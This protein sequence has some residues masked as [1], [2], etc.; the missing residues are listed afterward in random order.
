MAEGIELAKAYVQIIPSA[1]GIQGNL[2]AALT[3]QATAAGK[4]AGKSMFGAMLGVEAVKAAAGGLTSFAKS[5][6]EVG[7]EFDSSMSQ[8]AATLGYTTEE[9]SD[10]GSEASQTL[11]TLRAFAR[12]MGATTA[13]SAAEAAD[14]LNYMALAGYDAQT[15]MKMLPNVLNLAAAGGLDLATASDMITDAGSALNLT[16]ED[17]SVNVALV[18]D[19]V[20][21][22]AKASSKS[23][24]SVGQLG[25]AILTIGGTAN[26][27]AGGTERLSTVLGLLADNGIK[28]S[29][30]GTHLRNMILKLASPTDDGAAAMEALGLSVFDAEGKM[31]D[32]QDIFGDL[33]KAFEGMTDEKKVQYISA[34]FNSRDIAS[35]N[36][37]LNTT[38]ERWDELAAAIVDSKDA[39]GA[40]AD[41][42]LDNL[43][44]DTKILESAMSE[45]KITLSQ[46]MSP[47]IRDITQGATGLITDV[48][49]W[50]KTADIKG[51]LDAIVGVIN[52]V[53]G[54]ISPLTDEIIE[55]FSEQEIASG[56]AEAFHSV[57]DGV[58]EVINV[59]SYALADIIQGLADFVNWLSGGSTEAEIFKGVIVAITAAFV[60]YQAIQLTL[61]AVTNGMAIAQG[62]LN[63]IMAANP[64]TIVTLAIVGL[65]AG[66]IYLWNNCDAFREFLTGMFDGI[67]EFFSYLPGFFGEIGE[68]IVAGWDAVCEFFGSLPGFFVDLG[69]S[70]GQAWNDIVDFLSF[71]PDFFADLISGAFSWGS[72]MIENFV[73]G[74]KSVGSWVTDGVAAVGQGIADFLG[75]SEPDKGPLSNFHTY[76]PDMMALFAEGIRDNTD[77]I[78]DQISDSF[79]IGS[80]INAA[81]SS[82]VSLGEPVAAAAGDIIIPVSIGADRLDTAIVKS[83]QRMNYRAG[84]R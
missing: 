7:K 42:Q 49:G 48:A 67:V 37:L 29:E 44:G 63:T 76:A 26:I 81:V 62:L 60:A 43:A 74:I 39:A 66:I 45:L 16:L 77:L 27:M 9:L 55:L 46:E 21:Q 18:T 65:V 56:T 34:L 36:A 79:N 80:D 68:G 70:I 61:T 40:M 1:D 17:G 58:L 20:D 64:V 52:D 2:T 25:D 30:A 82:T 31:R 75:F 54:A 15:S 83:Q 35:V 47:I 41:T 5:A 24:T 23:N 84:G 19:M 72:D 10:S 33:N 50:L 11:E 57:W 59:A 13:F 38:T 6:S 69:D 8:V 51:T 73:D 28:G 14:A 12:N 78:T 3:G 22:M 32:F 4:S 53:A 71:I